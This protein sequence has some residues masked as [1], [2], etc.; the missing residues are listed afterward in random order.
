MQS[1]QRDNVGLLASPVEPFKHDGEVLAESTDG[2]DRQF[3]EAD[4]LAELRLHQLRDFRYRSN[5]A[6]DFQCVADMLA[7]RV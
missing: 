4:R 6:A 5:I 3:L 1:P 7:R 2:L